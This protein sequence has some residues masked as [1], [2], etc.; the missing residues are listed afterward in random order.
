MT[1]ESLA[2]A[3]AASALSYL[4]RV[5]DRILEDEPGAKQADPE[6]YRESRERVRKEAFALFE[7]YP[8]LLSLKQFYPDTLDFPALFDEFQEKSGK[9]VKT[10]GV[11][12]V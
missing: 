6:G 10:F 7:A 8:G 4:A 3:R 12:V 1:S 2:Y 11:P 5:Q 9:G